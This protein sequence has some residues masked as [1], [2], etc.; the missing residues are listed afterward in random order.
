MSRYKDYYKKIDDENLQNWFNEHEPDDSYYWKGNWWTN[1][2]FIRDR[3][4]S[5]FSDSYEVVGSHYSK[6]IECPVVKTT[7]KGVEIIWQYNFYHWQIMIKSKK[8]LI[9]EDL[10]LLDADGDYLYYQGIPEEYCFKKYSLENNKEFAID[11]S[12]DSIT[13]VW[14]FALELRKVIDKTYERE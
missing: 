13:D 3:I 6:S 12:H 1:N 11:I 8:P 9:L 2:V 4:L 14:P 5:L 7:Y 10:S